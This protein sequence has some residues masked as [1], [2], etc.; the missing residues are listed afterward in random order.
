MQ[1]YSKLFG[2]TLKEA[3]KDMKFP[4]H[5]LLYRGGFVRELAAG[6]LEFLPLGFR[7]WSNI[8]KL[9]DEEMIKIGSQRMAIPLL[10]P[11][12]FWKKTN[13]DQA[14]KG[15]LMTVEDSR[16]AEFALSA[17]GEGVVTEMVAAEQPSYKD[18]PIIIHQT[19]AKFRDETRARGGLL[20]AREF[21]MKD[22]YSYHVDEEDFMKTYQDFHQAYSTICKRLQLPFYAVIADNGALGG[23]YSHEFQ[24]PCETGED[25]I[26]K[27]SKCEY[28]ANVEMAKFKRLEVNKEE[29]VKKMQIDDQKWE[30][31]QSIQDM[32]DCYKRPANNM[33]KTVVFKRPDGG[34]V[35]GVVT[36]DLGVNSNKLAK[37]VGES[38]LE[39]AEKADLDSIGAI[40]GAVHAWGYEEYADK[41]TFVVDESIV[42]AK[43][44]YG[45]YKTKT[46]DP[47][48][49][50]YGRDF[51]HKIEAD[52]A[53]PADG[54]TCS[55]CGGSLQLIRTIEFG[56]IFKYD[57]FYT[58]HH[59]GFFTDKEGNKKLMY[60]GAY[61]IG[62]GRTIATTVEIH[63]DEKG[64]IWPKSI[65]PY[66][67]HFVTLAEENNKQAE[68]VINEIEKL[69]LEVLWDERDT[70]AGEKFADADLIGIPIRVVLSKRSLEAGGFEVKVRSEKDSKVVSKAD[71]L[72]FIKKFY[73]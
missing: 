39:K 37:A 41:V 20:R 65:A 9:I 53:E 2:K 35:L 18:L 33:I 8:I 55:E 68:E 22:A 38:A 67:V 27:C 48:F 49:V 24:V 34:L 61:G 11:I 7:V 1:K 57:H 6:R 19:I 54:A 58:E 60:S 50:N 46:T 23:D 12:E 44:L 4:S 59:N 36:G 17:T 71:L 3:K 32:V 21:E 10:Q 30:D 28:A 73:A 13:R 14:W 29:E 5:K 40:G 63:H 25:Q 26:V 52:I 31:A 45:G 15:L 43:N 69:G 16:G 64:I 56:H 42:K 66:Q 62:I 47:H 70:T 51:K 72:K